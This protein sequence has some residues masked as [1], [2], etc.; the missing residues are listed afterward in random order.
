[1]AEKIT[2]DMN[3]IL[4][5]QP[6]TDIREKRIDYPVQGLPRQNLADGGGTL[7]AVK[8]GSKTGSI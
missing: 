7:D 2:S 1:M 4:P 3:P 8:Q 6:I 5:S